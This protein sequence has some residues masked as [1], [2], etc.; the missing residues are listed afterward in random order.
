MK[1]KNKDRIANK[2]E[3]LPYVSPTIITRSSEWVEMA[4]VF[5]VMKAGVPAEF[6][7]RFKD[8]GF[9][10]EPIII[11][12]DIKP[13]STIKSGKEENNIVESEQRESG[14]VDTLNI[15]EE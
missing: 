10:P 5:D 9:A 15:V 4:W 14:R 7:E 1:K 2:T 11:S 12:S 8:S 3:E 6:D 13:A